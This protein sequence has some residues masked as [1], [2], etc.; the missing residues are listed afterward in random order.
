MA[1]LEQ[2][3]RLVLEALEA[4]LSAARR[5]GVEQLGVARAFL[6]DNGYRGHWAMDPRT[7]KRLEKLYASLCKRL[8]EALE[9]DRPGAKML[10][11]VRAFLASQG[12]DKDFSAA[13]GSASAARAAELLGSLDV[14]FKVH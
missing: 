10:G 12:I 1:E 9:E 13:A 11:E 7:Q 6:A 4:R 3:H 2:L 8:A 5:P 14:P